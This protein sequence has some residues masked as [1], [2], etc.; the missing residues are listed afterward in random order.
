MHS[1]AESAA[2]AKL[3]STFCVG[4]SVCH[5]PG[6]NVSSKRLITPVLI[7]PVAMTSVIGVIASAALACRLT[8]LPQTCRVMRA[9]GRA[10]GRPAQQRRAQSSRLPAEALICGRSRRTI[11]LR[12]CVLMLPPRGTPARFPNAPEFHLFP[13]PLPARCSRVFF[14]FFAAMD[15]N[16]RFDM[17]NGAR[18]PSVS[19]ALSN[20]ALFIKGAQKAPAGECG[21]RR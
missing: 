18:W 19:L 5:D 7:S 3:R 17:K 8:P 6:D 11:D 1:R 10:T 4:R 20:G 2:G 12:R 16:K 21:L 15:S 13:R 9:P 14:L